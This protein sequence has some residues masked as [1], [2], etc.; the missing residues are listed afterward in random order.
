MAELTPL[1]R[2]L[3]DQ[4]QQ[5]V[6]VNK[7]DSVLTQDLLS[8]VH[9]WIGVL[10]H[11]TSSRCAVYHTDA[12][13]FLAI[14]LA[15]WQLKC[16]ACIPGD[17]R[18]GTVARLKGHVDSF[19]GEF[20]EGIAPGN[21]VDYSR[22][23]NSRWTVLSSDFIALEIYTSGST[24]EPKPI[25]KTIL[26]L[27]KELVA[28]ETRWPD[29]QDC[30]VLATVSHQ[31][32]YGMTF[33]LFWPFCSGQAFARRQ[34]EYSEDIFHHAKHFTAFALVSSPSHL[35][36]INTAI[37]WQELDGC[38][39]YLISSAAPLD[40][41]DSLEAG[42]LLSVAV[43]EVYG[44]SETGAIAW[45]V[46]QDSEDDALWQALPGVQLSPDDK[47]TLCVRSPYL[48]DMEYFTLPDSVAFAQDGRF[49]LTGRVDR[50]VKVEGKRVC[51]S[52]HGTTIAGMCNGQKMLEY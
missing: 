34:C 27:E 26:Q 42:R 51:V 18:P 32:L 25:T 35:T 24:G 23:D 1:S 15:L 33:R 8:R 45:R 17:I 5:I 22:L 29:R 52:C 38:C 10:H 44:S 46:Q 19:A 6:A 37:N 3:A 43:T 13:E 30:V 4:P 16:T 40:R 36:R 9:D 7:S 21:D 14:L 20:A 12:F 47:G 2:W 48:G 41:Q 31:H 50:I 28:L 11:Q 49:K 39:H